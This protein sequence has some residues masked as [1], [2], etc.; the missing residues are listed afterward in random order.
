M[1]NNFWKAGLLVV[2]L[3]VPVLLI[4]YLNTGQNHYEVA[5]FRGE[6]GEKLK[7]LLAEDGSVHHVGPFQFTDQ[8]GKPATQAVMQGKVAIADFIF[9][10]CQT[11]C[12]KM[13]AQ[14][15]RVQ[16]AL[17]DE[18]NLVILS[19]TVDPDYDTAQVLNQYAAEYKAIYGKW[20]LL[21]GPKKALYDHAR[22]QYKLPVPQG[23]GDPADFIHSDRMVLVDQEGR[24]RGFYNGTDK[25]K[26][27]T[28]ILEARI[29]LHG[30]GDKR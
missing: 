11:I 27:D 19:H 8:Q 15:T 16:D 3:V 25:L 12:P 5:N 6:E 29:L 23:D 4:F 9:T 2:L 10:R 20:Y 1:K 13:S 26:V 21:T 14:M 18:P 22:Y 24:I 30:Q 17:K 7:Y 28:L